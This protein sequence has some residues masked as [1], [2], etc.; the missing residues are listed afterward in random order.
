MAFDHSQLDP[1]T[2]RGRWKSSDWDDW[3]PGSL[4]FSPQDGIRLLL[5]EHPG[6]PFA[7]LKAGLQPQHQPLDI[8]HGI[9]MEGD[10]VTLAK[11]HYAGGGFR[12]N[13]N[14]A[15]GA[16]K[17]KALWMVV[18]EH[19][20]S[21]EAAKYKSVGISFMNL[22]EVI[23]LWPLP[24]SLPKLR[25]GKLHS[26]SVAFKLPKVLKARISEYTIETSYKAQSRGDDFRHAAIDVRAWLR[27]TAKTQTHIDQFLEG[28]CATLERFIGVTLGRL[29]TW[30]RI[31]AESDRTRQT[32]NGRTI[33]EP[34][35]IIFAPRS[36][37]PS[38]GRIHP[39]EL[40]FT[41]ASF[42]DRFR[43]TL[44]Q[45]QKR[46]TILAPCLEFFFSLDSQMRI[47]EEHHFLNAT[48]ALESYHRAASPNQKRQSDSEF[49]ERRADILSRVAPGDKNWLEEQLRYANEIRFRGRVKELFD[50]QPIEVRNVLGK[51]KNFVDKVINTRNYLTHHDKD[52]K[53]KAVRDIGELWRITR[54]LRLMLQC[55]FLK[56]IGLSGTHL[57]AA[58]KKTNDYRI[59]PA[60]SVP[61]ASA[62]PPSAGPKA[63][64]PN[65]PT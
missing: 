26:I 30:M 2:L 13:R 24:D 57:S 5:D 23:G 34:V 49:E 55:L 59:L 1:L 15:V 25:R 41:L 52:L 39:L 56:E 9:T 11:A 62:P 58:I 38:M 47:G 44:L 45:W 8:I 7:A 65:N 42:A 22:E 16:A 28:P 54:G 18:G 4:E 48:N 43:P 17:Y 61:P 33:S 3:F 53:D 50:G 20:Q 27:I 12:G 21:S 10:L 14:V 36:I 32:I 29:P 64:S 35:S 31:Q 19:L 60:R 63:E 46:A 37:S 6:G 51:R 40:P